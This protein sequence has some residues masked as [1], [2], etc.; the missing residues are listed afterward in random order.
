LALEAKAPFSPVRFAARLA[1]F[2]L[3]WTLAP[4]LALKAAP[5]LLI[6]GNFEH[7]IEKFNRGDEELTTNAIPNSAAW[8]W[9]RSNIPWFECSNPQL[10][11]IY[12]FRWWTWR[13][14]IKLTPGGF[15]VTE[16]LPPVPWAGKY[17]TISCAAGH[18]IYEGRWLHDPEYLNDYI[19][20]WFRGGGAPRLYSDWLADAVYHR[21]LVNGDRAF[22]VEL[23]PDLIANY[24]AREKSNFDAG[25][26]LFWQEDG[27][28]GMEVSIGGSG[29]RAT[30][31]SYMY[32]D[33]LA[34]A[35]IAELAGDP[36]IG[37]EFRKKAS[38]LQER[39]ESG[40]WDGDARFFKVLP[41]RPGAAFAA[42]RELPGVTTWYFNLPAGMFDVAWKQ[43]TDPEGFSAPYG[44]TT[45]ERRSPRFALSYQGHEC[46]WNGPSWPYATS[47]TLTALANLLNREPQNIIGKREFYDLLATYA[48]SQH[49]TRDDGRVVPWIDENL[50]PLTGDWIARTRLKTWRNG[51]WSAEKGGAERGK[52]YNHSTFNDLIITGLIGLRPEGPFSIQVNPLI[53]DGAL[54]YFCLDD[55]AYRGARLT[56]FW[57]STGGRY[58]RGPGLRVLWDGEECAFSKTLEG[59]RARNPNYE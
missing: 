22:V 1:V 7:Y 44:P 11:E 12:Y 59:M 37:A 51:G 9:M 52:D 20:F 54:D 36:A 53:P 23:L 16:F 57:D 27:R 31:N 10:E 3:L 26:G 25:A 29:Y 38:R 21:F 14:H 55:V 48:N 17:N 19:R 32:G 15:V 2:P 46:Q 50:N 42:A 5:V 30:L 47:V 40:L 8:E 35:A 13:K 6:P 24:R 33:A 58:H 45:A 43:L 56:I 4:P 18:H 28:D 41:R 39:V 34:I 49:R